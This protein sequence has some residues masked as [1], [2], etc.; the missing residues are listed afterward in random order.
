MIDIVITRVDGGTAFARRIRTDDDR[1]AG[2]TYPEIR[3]AELEELDHRPT[4]GEV[5]GISEADY[6]DCEVVPW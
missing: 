3:W 2:R 4:A 5:V 6:E 1:R